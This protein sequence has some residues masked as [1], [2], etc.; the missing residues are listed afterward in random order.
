M[1]ASLGASVVI[2]TYGRDHVLLETIQRVLALDPAPGE[3]LVVDQSPAHAEQVEREL[4]ALDGAGRIRWVRLDRPSIPGAMNLGLSLAREDVVIFLDDD[5][6]PVADLIG[7]HLAAQR[8]APFVAGQVLQPGEQPQPLAEGPQAPFSFRSSGRGPVD[9]LI[10]CNFSVRRAS[11]LSLGGFDEQFVAA[12]YRYER[13]FCDRVRRAGHVIL[14]EPLAGVRHLQA[15]AGGTRAFGHHLRTAR[16]GHSVGSYYYLLQSRPSGWLRRFLVRPLRSIR[17][18][19]HLR[20]PWWIL[21]TL[22]AEAAGMMWA[23]RLWRQGPRLVSSRLQGD[24][25][26][27][28]VAGS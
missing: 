5:V 19:H 27:E 17:T 9:E 10:G 26:P 25:Q 1:T 28:G 21:P 3:L 8:E 13:E 15:A 16:P 6:V 11:A 22:L 20:R 12:G 7:A 23:L 24:D 18:R 14:F 4:R 2:P